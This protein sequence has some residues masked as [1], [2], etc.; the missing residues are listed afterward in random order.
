MDDE[1]LE[2]LGE[3][4][5]VPWDNSGDVVPFVPRVGDVFVEDRVIDNLF[6]V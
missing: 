5:A 6:D 1:G 3:M 2:L 4:D